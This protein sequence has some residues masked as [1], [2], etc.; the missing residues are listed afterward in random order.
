MTDTSTLRNRLGGVSDYLFGRNATIGIASLMLLTISGYATW[1]GMNDFIVG[2]S[3]SSAN[4]DREMP[5]GLSVSNELLVIAIVT[6]LT[7]LMWLALRESFRARQLI[8]TRAITF[9][10]YLFLA[11]WSVGFG[12]GFWWSLIAGEEATRI[13]MD[14][15]QDNARNA[16]NLITARLEAVQAQLN[17]VVNWSESQMTREEASGGSC[18]VSSRAGRGP[19][20]QA[21]ASVRDS[22]SSL[23]DGITQG[24][25]EPVQ[26][27]I[28]RLTVS[29][30][31]GRSFLEKQRNFEHRAREIRITAEKIAA[32]SN[33]FGRSSAAEML[34]LANAVERKPQDQGFS[35]YDPTLAQRLRQ[36]AKQAEEP[37]TLALGKAQ[38]LEGPAGVAYAVKTLW[39]NVGA[40]VYA[41][42]N[43]IFS[44]GQEPSSSNDSGTRISGRDLIALLVTLGIDL[45]LFV[46]MALNPPLVPASRATG[47]AAPVSKLKPPSGAVVRQLASAIATAIARAPG[48]NLEWVRRHFVHHRGASYFVIP[49]LYSCSDEHEEELK[50]LAMN[51]LAGVFENVALVCALTEEEAQKFGEEEER[52]SS[53]DLARYQHRITP[54]G[55][56]KE[57]EDALRNHGLLS[58]SQRTLDIAGW[59]DK[60]KRDPEIYRLV[61]VEGLTP[62]LTLLSEATLNPSPQAKSD[63]P[64]SIAS[65][66]APLLRDDT[67]VNREEDAQVLS[68]APPS[69]PSPPRALPPPKED[70]DPT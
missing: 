24:W 44:G 28:A 36:A 14:N 70:T 11:L 21:R 2:V 31:E 26:S 49:N 39:S 43:Y 42:I 69:L 9:P 13:S 7:F 47:L 62:L 56:Q 40:Y 32:R 50:A 68:I 58:K 1:S 8:S 54:D 35:C 29:D 64:S 66:N 6:A 17:N 41:L 61:D 65:V 37:V 5:G 34:S 38:Y 16:G 15:L 48:A 51:Q 12:Y 59:S 19:L 22:V 67:P 46:L 57:P 30:I 27:D 3:T 55:T 45:G 52:P 20:Y 33:A 23:R 53:T 4:A 63:P 18:G 25:I 60:A 10:L